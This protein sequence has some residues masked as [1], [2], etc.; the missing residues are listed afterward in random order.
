MSP[1]GRF[2][3]N[4]TIANVPRRAIDLPERAIDL[5]E[6]TIHLPEH[7]IDLP[8]LE[9]LAHAARDEGVSYAGSPSGARS[10]SMTAGG[11]LGWRGCSGRTEQGPR[12]RVVRVLPRPG[13]SGSSWAEPPL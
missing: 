5:P 8:E 12:V 4:E 11:A 1:L 10:Q 6:R 3:K 13:S 2:V 7:A 9:R